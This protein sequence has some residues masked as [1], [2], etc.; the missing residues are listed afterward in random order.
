MPDTT[1]LTCAAAN[2]PLRLTNAVA[3]LTMI[4]ALALPNSG[5]GITG[6][7]INSVKGFTI[8]IPAGVTV[9]I[10]GAPAVPRFVLPLIITPPV[11][12][13]VPGKDVVALL[14]EIRPPVVLVSVRFAA[15]L[16]ASP[17]VMVGVAGNVAVPVGPPVKTLPLNVEVPAASVVRLAIGIRKVPIWPPKDVRRELLTTRN[18]P[19]AVVPTTFPVIVALPAPVLIVTLLPRIVMPVTV[20]LPPFVVSVLLN[21]TNVPVYDWS[22]FVVTS[23]TKI[24]GVAKVAAD[25]DVTDRPVNGVVAPTVVPKVIV[26]APELIASVLAPLTVP[27][28]RT[29]PELVRMEVA[30]ASVVV[31]FAVKT[32]PAPV[33]V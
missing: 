13:I 33:V 21:F 27:F 3:P 29:S 20:K 25:A 31:L 26:P 14:T 8:W 16:D 19:P 28:S 17:I 22:P 23:W 9:K 18:W 12:L 10:T 30:P 32:E 15:P 11:V 1:E 24:A 7:V 4:E 5:A 6:E 2:D